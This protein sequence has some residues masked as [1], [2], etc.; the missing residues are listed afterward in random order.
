MRVAPE[1]R[2]YTAF[3]VPDG[4][5]EFKR[6]PF[7]LCNSPAVFQRY[8]NVVLRELITDGIVLVYMDDII[9]PSVDPE[10][11]LSRLKCVLRIA[12]EAGLDINWKKCS[13]LTQK[14]EFLG[15]RI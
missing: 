4:H 14:V 12:G 3:V 7:G 6:L 1:S 2:K 13:F 15:H 9:I 5:L 8:V 10:N 11:G